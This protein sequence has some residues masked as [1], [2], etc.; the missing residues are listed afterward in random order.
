MMGIGIRSGWFDAAHTVMFWYWTMPS[1]R[2]W[3]SVV[4]SSSPCARN[5]FLHIT[6]SASSMSM[7]TCFPDSF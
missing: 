5:S 6:A 4:R 3:N 1:M 7:W 2:F